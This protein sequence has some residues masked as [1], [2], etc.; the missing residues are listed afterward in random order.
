M[1]VARNI[2][3]PQLRRWRKERGLTQP[4][5]VA[6]CNLLGWGLSRESLAKIET[7]IRWVADAELVCLAT[8]L[9]VPVEALLPKGLESMQS[10]FRGLEKASC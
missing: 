3:G 9:K 4:M 6:R 2:I 7:R 8:A 1:P 10:F 5:L